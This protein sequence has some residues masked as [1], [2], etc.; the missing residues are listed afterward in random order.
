M[1]LV[2][3]AAGALPADVTAYINSARTNLASGLIFG[4]ERAVPSA[5]DDAAQAAV[6]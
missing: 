6:N 4:G 1:L 2:D 5:L 3:P